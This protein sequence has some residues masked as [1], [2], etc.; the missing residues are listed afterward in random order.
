[1]IALFALGWVLAGLGVFL[2]G[3]AQWNNSDK[4]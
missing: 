1:M 3:L 2:I 4:P